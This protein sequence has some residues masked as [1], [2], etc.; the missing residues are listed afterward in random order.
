VELQRSEAIWDLPRELECVQGSV[1][2]ENSRGMTVNER[3][4][5]L[6][7]LDDF[8]RRVENRDWDGLRSLLQ[9]VN[10]TPNTIDQIIASKRRNT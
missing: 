7:L 10:L 2:T 8:D 5:S 3:L 1:P 6:G 4:F 9:Q